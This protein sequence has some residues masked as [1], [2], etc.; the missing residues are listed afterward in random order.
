MARALEKGEIAGAAIDVFSKEPPDPDSPL[1]YQDNVIATPHIASNTA[2]AN[3]EVSRAVI[4]NV[5]EVVDG[6]MPRA[7]SNIVN[8]EVLSNARAFKEA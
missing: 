6:R 2:E 1:L 8:R 7:P 5:C 3:L 4:E